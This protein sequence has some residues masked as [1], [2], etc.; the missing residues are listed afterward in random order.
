MNVGIY[1][2]MN[3]LSCLL[4]MLLFYQQR[5]HKVF[6]FLGTTEFNSILWCAVCILLVDSVSW[7]MVGGILPHT[8]E[9]LMF[10]QS[11]YYLLQSV[12]PLFFFMYCLDTS[13]IPVQNFWKPLLL[14]PVL[15]TAGALALNFTENFAFYIVESTVK[16][17]AGFILVV[18]APMIYII[19]SLILC[20]VFCFQNRRISEEKFKVSTHMLVCI[21][22]ST[23][24][25]VACIFVNYLNPWH[26]F[27]F[28]LVYLY[29]Q[30]HGFREHDLDALAFTDSLTGLRT[31]AAYTR[32]KDK[33]NEDL[34]EDPTIKFAVVM[35]DIDYLKQVND[36][37]GHKAGNAL[38]ISAAQLICDTFQHSPVCRIG[39]D[40][41]VAILKK[42]D[43]ENREMLC[44]QFTEQLKTT[45]FLTADGELPVSVS[46]GIADYQPEYHATFDA[47]FHAADE[48]MYESKALSKINPTA[49]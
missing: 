48:A 24:G 8:N 10:I 39:G 28:S 21:S 1:I 22:A 18:L 20:I 27:V 29:I 14:S 47:V 46:L 25:A 31:H 5:K 4:C 26:V 41:F 40:E 33:L 13:G 45:T 43:Y 23:L 36:T 15:Y 49:F 3:I 6:D 7:L 17:G 2:E 34:Q 38:I 35:A 11:I 32:I 19:N 37:Y 9:S 12:I 44:K 16:R 42:S 30:L